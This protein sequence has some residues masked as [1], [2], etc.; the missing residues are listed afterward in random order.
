M[1]HFD[2]MPSVYVDFKGLGG[3]RDE[4]V[5]DRAKERGATVRYPAHYNGVFSADVL[6]HPEVAARM[7]NFL[8]FAAFAVYHQG[9]ALGLGDMFDISVGGDPALAEEG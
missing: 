5:R 8:G 4:E 9:T 7:R 1:T 2:V 3:S 6:V